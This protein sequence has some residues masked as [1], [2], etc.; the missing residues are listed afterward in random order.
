MAEVPEACLGDG[1]CRPGPGCLQ[2]EGVLHWIAHLQAPLPT[3]WSKYRNLI[4]ISSNVKNTTRKCSP[5]EIE[6]YYFLAEH[7]TVYFVLQL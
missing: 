2:G 6:S 5:T 4:N 3:C 1:L 7:N